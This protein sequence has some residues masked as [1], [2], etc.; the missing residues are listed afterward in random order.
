MLQVLGGALRRAVQR[1]TDRH[2]AL[3][4]IFSK[5]DPGPARE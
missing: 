4:T 5:R 2:A 3:R 1:L